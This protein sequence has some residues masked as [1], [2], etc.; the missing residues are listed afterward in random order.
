MKLA[1]PPRTGYNSTTGASQ[2]SGKTPFVVPK[3]SL[4]SWLGLEQ[5]CFGGGANFTRAPPPTPISKIFLVSE[6]RIS[7]R[8]PSI[9][10]MTIGALVMVLERSESGGAGPPTKANSENFYIFEK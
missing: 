4:N 9:F 8:L 6:S 10:G 5:I 7:G 3:L 2:K 1:S